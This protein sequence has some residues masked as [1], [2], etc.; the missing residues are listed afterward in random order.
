MN[1]HECWQKCIAL[2]LL[3]VFNDAFQNGRKEDEN[4]KSDVQK[5]STR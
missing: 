3:V 1:E 2:R 4:F 5:I